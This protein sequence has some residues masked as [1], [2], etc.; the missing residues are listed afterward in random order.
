MDELAK[1]SLQK[2]NQEQQVIRSIKSTLEQRIN[3]C[4]FGLSLKLTKSR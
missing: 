1:L 4:M 3:K 2:K